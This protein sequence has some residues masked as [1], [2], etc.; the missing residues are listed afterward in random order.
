MDGWMDVYLL[1]IGVEVDGA[2]V[3]FLYTNRP[4]QLFSKSASRVSVR[5]QC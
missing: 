2:E 1:K 3:V 4:C 5:G